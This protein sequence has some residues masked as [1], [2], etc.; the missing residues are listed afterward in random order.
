MK[1][2]YSIRY[3]LIRGIVLPFFALYCLM[4]VILMFLETSVAIKMNQQMLRDKT[5]LDAMT[6]EKFFAVAA[7]QAEGLARYAEIH[8]P[9]SPESIALH[10]YELLADNPLIVGSAIVFQTGMFPGHS[11]KFAPFFYRN[12]DNPAEILHKDLTDHDFS[13][14][15]WHAKPKATGRSC[16]TE[17]YFD[18]GGAG[19]WMC[20]YS[21]PFFFGDNLAGMATVDITLNDI[22]TH[23]RNILD[24]D[25]KDKKGILF[26][27][28]GKIIASPKPEWDANETID[29]LADKLHVHALK[30]AKDEVADAELNFYY[31]K[32]LLTGEDSVFV[33]MPLEDTGWGLLEWQSLYAVRKPIYL[34]LG[35]RITV[36]TLGLLCSI[37]LITYMARRITKPLNELMVF[38]VDVS[39]GNL[40]AS[41]KNVNTGDEVQRLA[42]ILNIMASSLQHSIDEMIK[43]RT[44]S[45]EAS[46]RAK[47]EFLSLASHELRTPINGIL[48]AVELL[49]KTPL[50][51][52]QHEYVD[53]QQESAVVLQLL[54]ANILDYS[55]LVADGITVQYAVF[56]LRELIE[57]IRPVLLFLAKNHNVNIA[58]QFDG[59]IQDRVRGDAVRLRQVLM[60]LLTNAVKFS[61]RNHRSG[62]VTLVVKP[63]AD[64][65]SD[66]IRFE[67]I[68]DGIGIS[69]KRQEKLLETWHY[70][71]SDNRLYDG[72]GIGLTISKSIVDAMQGKIGLSSDADKGSIFWIEIPL[73]HVDSEE[74]NTFWTIPMDD[75]HKP[76]KVLIAEDNKINQMVVREMLQSIGYETVIAENGRK[77]IEAWESGDFDAI[78]MDCQMP[79]M[80]GYEASCLI[81]RRERELSKKPIPIIALTANV[82]P[83]DKQRC[84]DAGMNAYFNKPV[85]IRELAAAIKSSLTEQ[86][87]ST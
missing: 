66:K 30:Q 76:L 73:P 17:P 85:Q 2:K 15:E 56:R 6:C 12:K 38:A 32:G 63:A 74:S 46:S 60:N 72:F 75:A 44:E 26:S 65:A 40:N 36:Y 18:E 55:K 62:N 3:K 1:L 11:E 43:S 24:R 67:V 52:K 39:H 28:R 31:A 86:T 8:R 48:S 69:A 19:V 5:A 49:L 57:Q 82:S 37:G 13:A 14:E 4:A 27:T 68:D 47:T 23:M 79:E 34:R 35:V 84:L 16:W 33:A 45:A 64:P 20:T 50:T 41:V 70:N 53:I 61:A 83:G 87:H 25:V 42:E 59:E 9:E 10:I 71:V 78:L 80:D 58:I 81:R 51:D 7:E 21:V 54:I 77:A 29:T 22:H